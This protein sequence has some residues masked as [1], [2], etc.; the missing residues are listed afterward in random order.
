MMSESDQILAIPLWINGHAYLTMPQAFFDVRDAR[1]GEVKRRTP[2]CGPAEALAAAGSAQAA[3]PD[4]A[5]RTVAERAALLVALAG[6]L[7]EYG[8]HFA[9]LV[10][11]ET[12][13]DAAL[14]AAE[15]GDALSLLRGVD[16]GAVSDAAGAAVVAIVSDDSAPLFGPLR[17]AVPALLAGA[18]VVVKP[19]PKAPSAAFALAEL[20]ARS[21]FP[22]GVFNV[23][24]GDLA[25]IE[26]LC[27][28]REVS[29]LC[30]AGDPALGAKV[31]EVAIRYGKPFVD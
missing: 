23:L 28:L 11:E 6:T 3:L 14:A 22:G 9:E 24:H 5:A 26:G 12:G 27:V 2:L 1:S 31:A 30:F 4:W 16:S 21:D 18:T 13:K 29:R 10:S 20:T 8:E 15:V 7:A 17:H 25:A 19:S